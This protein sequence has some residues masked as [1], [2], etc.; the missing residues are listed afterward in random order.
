[1][2]RLS[3]HSSPEWVELI[4]HALEVWASGGDAN[5]ALKAWAV[6]QA[7]TTASDV[8]GAVRRLVE[9]ALELLSELN[10]QHA[11]VI[12]LRYGTDDTVLAVAIEL[13]LAE[14][15]I[16]RVQ[17]EALAALAEIVWQMEASARGEL[18][19]TFEG[20]LAAPTYFELVGVERHLD[21]LAQAILSD[22]PPWILAIEGMGGI[23]KTALADA[24]LRRLIRQ[25]SPYGFAWATARQGSG[26]GFGLQTR[27]TGGVSTDD[28]IAS[29]VNQLWADGQGKPATP[30]DALAALE[31]RLKATPHIVVID[32]LET[33][34]DVEIL[35]PALRRLAKPSKFLLT[36]RRS[37]YTESDIYHFPLPPLSL[38]DSIQLVRKEARTKNLAAVAELTQEELTPIYDVVGGNP[39]A[40]LLVVGQCH[41]RPLATVLAELLEAQSYQAEQLYTHI[42]WRI[43]ENLDDLSRTVLMAMQIVPPQGEDQ[44]FLAGV[45]ELEAGDLM[46]GIDRLMML[47]LVDCTRRRDGY[48]YSIHSLTRSFLHQQA[49]IWLTESRL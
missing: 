24:L 11:R 1:M 10:P 37:L 17:R 19:T 30:S 34:A 22:G 46:K 38:D 43:W 9:D 2:P 3:S 21:T 5:D 20:R 14:S 35:L 8:T 41:F 6:V 47:N 29:L 28:I 39:L 45:T 13:N 40:L 36:S 31:F 18:R 12:R 49:L 32:N 25:N 26:M 33:V 7:H 23:G 42:F 4:K 16:Y 44:N 27:D 15:S 48:R